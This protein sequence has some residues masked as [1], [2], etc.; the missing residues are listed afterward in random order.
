MMGPGYDDPRRREDGLDQGSRG[1]IPRLMDE[2]FERIM[3]GALG[4]SIVY[5]L[6]KSN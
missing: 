2:I 6:S 3:S 1:I 5:L 4:A